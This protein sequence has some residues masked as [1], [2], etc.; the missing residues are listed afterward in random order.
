MENILSLTRLRDGKSP[1]QQTAGGGGRGGGGAVNH[2]MMHAQEHEIT[3]QVP[4]ELMLVPMDG[5]LIEQ[6]LIN[7]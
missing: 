2:V 3:V 1:P 6:V 5:K 4:D 7:F